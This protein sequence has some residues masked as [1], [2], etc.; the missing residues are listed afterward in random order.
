M[1]IPGRI[2]YK[3]KSKKVENS[4]SHKSIGKIV[5][6]RNFMAVNIIVNPLKGLLMREI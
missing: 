2:Q 1:E 6:V 3:L 4:R 5:K